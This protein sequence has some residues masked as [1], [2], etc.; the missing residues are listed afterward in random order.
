MKFKNDLKWRRFKGIDSKMRFKKKGKL[1][2]LSIGW[3]LFKV[4]CG[5]YLSGYEEVFV[6]NVKEFEVIDLIR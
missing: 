3:S 6:Y 5:F 4:V 2:L 1:C